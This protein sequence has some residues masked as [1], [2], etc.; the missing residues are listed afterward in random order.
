MNAILRQLL[1]HREGVALCWLGNLG[2]LLRAEGRLLGIDLDLDV[3]NRI[4][5]SPIPTADLAAALDILFITHAHGDHFSSQTGRILAAQG[6]C[7]FVLPASCLEKA[8]QLKIPQERIRVARPRQPFTIDSI[9]IEPQRAL[10]GHT[11]FSV[12]RHANLDD[13][14]YVFTLAGR[15]LYQPGDT[16]LLHEH[17][18]DFADVDV[19][20]LS[21]TLHNTH[22][23]A[24]ARFAAAVQP[25]YIFPQHFATYQVDEGNSFWTVGYP[26]QLRQ[27]LPDNLKGCFHK[28]DQGAVFSIQ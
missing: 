19:L 13:C 11:G 20:F 21:P 2:W 14:G 22:I 7:R 26:D 17:L 10:H 12:Y 15:R 3:A 16:V 5:P 4:Q 23:E 1:D 8:E 18:E 9:P 27:A 25:D 24:S 6:H 28:L